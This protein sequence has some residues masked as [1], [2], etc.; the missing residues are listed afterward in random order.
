MTLPF[1]N[2]VRLA[3]ITGS[4]LLIPLVA[5]QFTREVVWTLSD[6]VFAG[7]LFF[8]TGLAYELVANR[9]GSFAY[10][11][12]VGLALAAGLLLV[13]VN[14]A[15]G[16]IG[17]EQNPAN[18]LYGGVLLTV[19]FGSILARLR[20]LGMARTMLAAAVVQFLV[21]VVALLIWR[22]ELNAGV[23]GVFAVNMLW[24]VLWVGSA[25]LFRRASAA[26]SDAA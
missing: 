20:P 15:V 19:F 8:G 3:L 2:I 23:A 9:K 1:K 7:V 17:G 26:R 21:P 10:R 25:L 6:F 22:P 14:A 5:M 13:W 16:L 4:L 11:G 18:L 24:V 12:A